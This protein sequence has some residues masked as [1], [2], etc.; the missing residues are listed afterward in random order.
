[1]KSVCFSEYRCLQDECHFIRQTIPDDTKFSF[2][3]FTRFCLEL[4][5]Q[6]GGL[7]VSVEIST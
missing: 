6:H 3:C 1:M 4:R 5:Q 7:V 2:I